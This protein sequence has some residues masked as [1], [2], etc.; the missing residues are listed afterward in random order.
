[1]NMFAVAV[2]IGKSVAM[3]KNTFTVQ[4]TSTRATSLSF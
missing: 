3:Q 2:T 1:M 4:I